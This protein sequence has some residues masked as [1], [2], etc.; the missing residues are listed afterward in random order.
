MR[1]DITLVTHRGL[2]HGAQDDQRL[3]EALRHRGRS[4]RF[5][6]W[7]DEAVD[8]GLSAVTLLRSTWDYHLAPQAWLAW[9]DRLEG[10]TRLINPP[11]LVRWNTDKRYLGEL[12][13]RGAPCLPT[14]FVEGTAS[15]SLASIAAGQAWSDV[16]IKPAIGASARGA[17]R[18]RE[19][20]I[21]QAGE[22]HLT[23]LLQDGA[24]L[25]QP[26]M[27]VVEQAEERCLVFIGGQYSHAFVKPAFSSGAVGH[28][29]IR[30][31]QASAAELDMAAQVL[32]AAPSASTY[33][34]VDLIPGEQGPML[35]E[36]ELIEPDMAL[37]LAPGSIERLAQVCEAVLLAQTGSVR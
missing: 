18:F 8:W 9:L 31:H 27:A 21:A 10:Q 23:L 32:A 35:M 20:E 25:V 24:V 30:V 19:A 36:L 15:P 34:R 16:V 37:R 1:F 29:S 12:A 2:P 17:R 4:V 13:G 7:D 33:A 5:A 22:Q 14:V 11:T 28:A 6:V 3:A 26:Y